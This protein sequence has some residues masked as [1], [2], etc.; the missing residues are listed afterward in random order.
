MEKWKKRAPQK[1]NGQIKDLESLL[2]A[3]MAPVT[4][5]SEFVHQLQKRLESRYDP[6]PVNIFQP[7]LLYYI[8]IGLVGVFSGM[9][10]TVMGIKWLKKSMKFKLILQ[11]N[12]NVNDQNSGSQLTAI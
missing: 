3:V 8:A 4:P 10:I 5:R 7:E 12:D 6:K 2:G 11:E 9:L 1:I